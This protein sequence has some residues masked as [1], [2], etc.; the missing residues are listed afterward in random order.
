MKKLYIILT[1][2]TG[3]FVGSCNDDFMERYPLDQITD[4]NFWQTG[5][6]LELYCNDLYAQYIRGFSY[7]WGQNNVSPYGY[8]E[9]TIPYGDVITDNAAPDSY[10]RVTNNEYNGHITGGSGSGGWS[11]GNMRKL[12]Y[13]LDNY[14]RGDVD[15]EVRNVY[16]G[17]VLF[18][19]AWDYFEK[20]KLF[21][22]VPWYN[23][24]LETDSEELYAPR[25]PRAEVMDSVMKIL[26]DAIAYLPEKGA[27]KQGRINKDVALHLKSRIGLFEGTYRKYHN[28][29]GLDGSAFLEA[30]VQASET[31]MASG[32]SI[33]TTGNTDADYNALFAQYSYADNPEIILWKEYSANENLGVAFSRYYA[34]NLRH[35]HGATRD[36][37]DSYLCIDGQ[38]IAN[39]PLFEGKDS[40]Q[41]EMLHRDPRL[42]QT[43]CNFGEYAL[44]E[45]AMGADNAPLPNIPGLS[46]NK[47]PTGYRVGKWFFNEPDDWGRLTNGMQAAPVFRYAEILLNYAEARYELG[48]LSQGVIDQTINVIRSRVNMPALQ[49][50]NIPSDPVLDQDYAT[51]CDYIPEPV[52]REIRRERRIELAFENFRWD[53]LMRWKAGKFLEKPVEGI[54]FV[55]EQFP[56]VVVGTDVFLSSEGYILPY[57]QVLPDGRTWDDRQYLFPIPIEDLVLNPELKQNPD[58]ES[59]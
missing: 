53:D 2:C 19:K 17:E 34:Q 10:S 33:Y 46:G 18:F 20:V 5:E 31:L 55:Q 41:Q 42:R 40:I 23:H 51:Y 32:Y 28:E 54:K 16:L 7:G 47:C 57:F 12:N 4:E 24:V 27:Q 59:N 39:S 43:I 3:F 26:D 9:A 1:L 35:R 58:W 6:D 29:L 49:L 14:Q 30:S 38:P 25:T 21:G 48:Q 45:G 50:G 37:V 44:A 22:N 56:S 15:P 36:L 52:L 13:F 8:N 11:W